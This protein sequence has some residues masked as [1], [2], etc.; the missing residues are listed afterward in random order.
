MR[1]RFAIGA[2]DVLD[3]LMTRFPWC[4]CAEASWNWYPKTRAERNL[5]TLQQRPVGKPQF[6]RSDRCALCQISDASLGIPGMMVRS[7]LWRSTARLGLYLGL[8]HRPA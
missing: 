8:Y 2:F 7:R 5:Y 6:A 3:S 1:L 4:G